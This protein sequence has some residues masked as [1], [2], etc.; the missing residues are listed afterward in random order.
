MQDITVRFIDGPL[1]GQTTVIEVGRIVIGRQPGAGGLELKGAD[2]SVSRA[3]AE[4]VEQDGKIVV[5][6][7][8]PN[9]TT[10]NGKLV[11]DEAPIESGAVVDIGNQF[12]LELSWTSFGAET[13]VH[14]EA[15]ADAALKQGPLSS[16]IVRTVIVV[17]LV[18]MAAVGLWFGVFAGDDVV[19]DDWPALIAAYENYQT[20][21]VPQDVWAARAAQ[22]ERL[23]RELRELKK[24][25]RR[26]EIE[27]ICRELTHIDRD[28]DSPLYKY[29]LRN[30]LQGR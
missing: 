12:V 16:P 9:G 3:H 21:D 8:S 14:S 13:I 15:P 20:E 27:R 23:V 1:R 24:Q 10:V 17:Y 25:G 2:T 28:A 19:A 7:Q 4:L 11:I 5:R 6:N 30:C 29:G 26:P 22:A 18:G